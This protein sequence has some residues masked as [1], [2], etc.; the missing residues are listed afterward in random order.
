M[1]KRCDRSV[2]MDLP[3]HF[4]HN[5]FSLQPIQSLIQ[6]DII[7][8]IVVSLGQQELILCCGWCINVFGSGVW[9]EISSVIAAVQEDNNK[10]HALVFL[11]LLKLCQRNIM[12][13]QHSMH[14]GY[15]CAWNFVHCDVARVVPF[16][17][18]VG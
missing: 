1:A 14:N 11:L 18:G 10:V 5:M 16:V 2:K 6:L 7:N 9:I 13:L 4:A 8:C 12:R 17:R 3:S 15:I